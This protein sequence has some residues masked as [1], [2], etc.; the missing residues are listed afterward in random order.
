MTVR[1]RARRRARLVYSFGSTGSRCS[2]SRIGR[3]IN[4]RILD[5]HER[6]RHSYTIARVRAAVV[7]IRLVVIRIVIIVRKGRR[8]ALLTT[9]TRSTCG[10]SLRRI[11][12]SSLTCSGRQRVR[13]RLRLG[14][15]LGLVR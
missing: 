4:W 3:S 1:V 11:A 6:L 2:G 13:L 7:G 8:V 9:L 10:L 12:C 14:R 5:I 15:L